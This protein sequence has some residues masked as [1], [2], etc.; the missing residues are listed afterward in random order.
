[1][2]IN[3][4]AGVIA[5]KAEQPV[6]NDKSAA[7]PKTAVSKAAAPNAAAK[8]S[9]PAVSRSAASLIASSGLPADKLS[10]SI[11]SFAR[12]FSLPLKPEILADIRRQAFSNQADPVKQETAK[13]ESAPKLPA[14]AR[15]ALS[16][17]AAAAEA[18]GVELQPKTLELF[19]QA[20]DPERRKQDGQHQEKKNRN[21]EENSILNPSSLK[22]NAL[23]EAENDPLLFILNRLPDKNGGRWIVLPFDFAQDGCEYKVSMRVLV[24]PQQITNRALYMALDIVVIPAEVND[25]PNRRIFVLESANNKIMKLSVYIQNELSKKDSLSIQ[26]EL[27]KILEIPSERVVVKTLENIFPFESG[28]EEMFQSIDEEA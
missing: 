25:T 28:E 22:K 27:S 16:L 7:Q 4:T 14:E 24:E 17:A 26:G 21:Q 13:S 15:A 2:Q 6:K 10:S 8:A 23:E 18:K 20:V 12:F 5:G 9:A 11:I 3:K 19:A 1:L